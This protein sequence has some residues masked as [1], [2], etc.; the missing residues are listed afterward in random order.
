MVNTHL[1]YLRL[2]V[3]CISIFFI[4]I[5]TGRIYAQPV[6]ESDTYFFHGQIR[7]GYYFIESKDNFGEITTTP[8]WRLRARFGITLR[9]NEQTHFT[10]RLAGRYSTIQDSFEFWH[11]PYSASPSGLRL[12]Q[13]AFDMFHVHWEDGDRWMIQGGRMQHGFNLKGILAKGLDRYHSPNVSI[14]WTDGVWLRY[15]FHNDWYIHGIVQFNH[16][17]GST[18]FF[19][20][21][22]NFGEPGSRLSYFVGIEGRATSGLW[23]QREVSITL[24]PSS[25]RDTE[26]KV[27]DYW[28]LT[29]RLG[30]NLPLNIPFMDVMIAGA[31]GYAPTT[32]AKQQLNL[33]SET[34]KTEDAFAFQTSINFQNIFERHNFGILY[35]RTDPGWLIAPSFRNNTNTL[36][37]RHQY[38]FNRRLSSEIRYRIRNQLYKPST[39]AIKRKDT[40][41]YARFTF[42]F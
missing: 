39:S 19:T 25:F 37:V 15:L 17:K 38:R 8:E 5:F 3:V 11:Y 2:P 16:S 20:P 14:A 32:P 22:L 4:F 40:D 10:A 35:G 23:N 33:S 6:L 9:F 13:T 31:T 24:I 26:Y 27:S 30:V 7:T 12:G 28:A 42:R 21:P 29:G 1:H 36:E 18:S 41:L 34:L